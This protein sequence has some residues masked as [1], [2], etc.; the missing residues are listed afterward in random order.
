LVVWIAS[1]IGQG[2][3][4][5]EMDRTELGEKQTTKLGKTGTWSIS[6]NGD[7]IEAFFDGK[8]FTREEG[9]GVTMLL[10]DQEESGSL[11]SLKSCN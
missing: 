10:I 2:S 3:K 5:K 8:S 11:G 4:S 6:N 1:Y 7:K 9:I